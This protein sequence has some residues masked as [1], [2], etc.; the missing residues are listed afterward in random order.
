M[1]NTVLFDGV[2]SVNI[3]NLPEAAWTT[4]GQQ[5][6]GEMAQRYAAVP[7]LWRGVELRAQSVSTLPFAIMRQGAQEPLDSSED[8][9]NKVEYLPNPADLLYL[10]ESSLVLQGMAYLFR[11]RNLLKTKEL[12]YM[13][14]SS[15]KPE[16]DKVKGALSHFT[17]RRGSSQER[18]EIEDVIYFWLRDP[19]VEI[20]PPAD[21][22]CPAQAALQAAGV[23]YNLDEFAAAFFER[24]AIKATLLKTAAFP[25]AAERARLKSWWR[26]VFQGIGNAFATE[27]V[28]SDTEV[29]VIGEGVGELADTNLTNTMRE[30]ISTALGIPQ[31]LLFSNAANFAVAQQDD[32]HFYSK[33][34]VPEALFIQGILNEQLFR[35]EGLQFEF[36]P[37]TLDIFQEDEQ[38][39]SEALARYVQAGFR[40]SVACQILG[41]ELPPGMDYEDLDAMREEDREKAAE[42][43][44]SQ[45]SPFG[46]PQQNQQNPQ[47]QPSANQKAML[48]DLRAWR[49]KARKAGG[50]VPFE[51]DAIPPAVMKSINGQIEAF[52]VDAAF[53]FLKKNH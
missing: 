2:K 1:S 11:G 29:E 48:A 38:Q 36:R 8:Y 33:T 3:N 12:R 10:I 6:G 28:S 21:G 52:G 47:Q 26:R 18:L 14:A 9:Q 34:V 49:T 17:R 45:G 22:K 25:P 40:L 41:V 20:G 23:L 32:L 7:W 13:V 27:I 51:S 15:I 53:E 31:S 4:L 42:R 16:Y 5:T 37:E 46:N 24:G 43:M 19:F 39:R 30:D 50:V 35:Q 44:A